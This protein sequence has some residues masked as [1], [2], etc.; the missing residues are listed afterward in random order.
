VP[1]KHFLQHIKVRGVL[2]TQADKDILDVAGV[3][4]V[5]KV[6]TTEEP[7]VALDHISVTS[8][9]SEFEPVVLGKAGHDAVLQAENAGTELFVYLVGLPSIGV[10]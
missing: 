1:I 2:T 6:E 3:V 10:A 4:V 9:E 5:A 7:T 8:K